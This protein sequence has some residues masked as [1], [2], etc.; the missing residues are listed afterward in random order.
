LGNA[1]T[2]S[3]RGTPGNAWQDRLAEW[4]VYVVA[5]LISALLFFVARLLEEAQRIADDHSQIV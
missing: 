3:A 2:A 4:S 1:E 5:L